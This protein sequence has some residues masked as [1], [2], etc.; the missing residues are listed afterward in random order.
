MGRGMIRIDCDGTGT[1]V[2]ARL[3]GVLD[4]E[5]T[6]KFTASLENYIPGIG[7]ALLVDL[8]Q[9]E[10]IDSSG[11]GALIKIVTRARLRQGQVIIVAPTAFVRGVF[12]ATR[13]DTW[14]DICTT[15]EAALDRLRSE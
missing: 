14:F 1:V 10:L 3:C 11:L 12:E 4:A 2:V 5:G 7:A 15:L 9:V 8:S 6:E 13:L